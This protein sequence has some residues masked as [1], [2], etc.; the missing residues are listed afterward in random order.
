MDCFDFLQLIH[1]A[2]TEQTNEGSEPTVK[3]NKLMVY[4]PH[5]KQW[6]SIIRRS[7]YNHIQSFIYYP[8]LCGMSEGDPKKT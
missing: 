7:A 3:E 8:K 5:E 6:Q 2:A 4:P 1:P